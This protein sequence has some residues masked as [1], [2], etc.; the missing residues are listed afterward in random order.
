MRIHP[1]FGFTAFSADK[2]KKGAI[3]QY[4]LFFNGQ[5][6]HIRH[7]CQNYYDADD[8]VDIYVIINQMIRLTRKNVW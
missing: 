6:G 4:L 1:P 7:F 2:R 8:S 3:Q 5:E